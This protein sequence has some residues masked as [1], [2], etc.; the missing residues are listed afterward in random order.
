MIVWVVGVDVFLFLHI[1]WDIQMFAWD[2]MLIKWLPAIFPLVIFKAI[3]Q[4]KAGI[5]A[6][7]CIPQVRGLSTVNRKKILNA[8]KKDQAWKGILFAFY[9]I[10]M[11][12]KYIQD[13]RKTLLRVWRDWLP[14]TF[15]SL[16][17]PCSGR[18]ITTVFLHVLEV[19]HW[20]KVRIGLS[21]FR[22]LRLTWKILVKWR[23]SFIVL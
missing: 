14:F 16:Y 12:Q 18:K 3:S 13:Q 17:E 21:C 15:I 8:G 11:Q 4:N 23:R 1:K 9:V 10:S 2:D 20:I 7:L 19:T 5:K 6:L 22:S